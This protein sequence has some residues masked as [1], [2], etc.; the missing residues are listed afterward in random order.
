MEYKVAKK[1]RDTSF[2]D[3]V[4]Q[5]PGGAFASAGKAI[6]LKMKAKATGFQEKFDPM[7]MAKVITGGSRWAPAL[8]GR[9]TGRKQDSIEHFAG[10]K[11]QQARGVTQIP[12]MAPQQEGEPAEDMSSVL[13]QMFTFMKKTREE[14]VKARA[15]RESFAEE[16]QNE[17]QRKHD[18]FIEVLRKYTNT[19]TATPVKKEGGGFMDFVKQLIDSVKASFGTM[20]EGVYKA[21]EWI[22]K[23]GPKLKD[24]VGFFAL[25]PIGIGLLAG[26]TLLSLL[27]LDKNAEETTKGILGAG[28]EGAVGTEIMKQQEENV[29][30]EEIQKKQRARKALLKDAP[31][32]TRVYQ[33]NAD[34]YLEKLGV[35]KEDRANL[36][37]YTV[38]FK[39]PDKLKDVDPELAAE[40][41]NTKMPEA[42]ETKVGKQAEEASKP[43]IPTTT[44]VAPQPMKME[45]TPVTE[46]PKSSFLS[47]LI[48]E[49]NDLNTSAI[50]GITPAPGPIVS[51]TSSAGSI[52]DKQISSSATQRDTTHILD[53]VQQAS[54]VHGY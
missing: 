24:I 22:T 11:R 16:R 50:A 36:T 23:L 38:P 51:G 1:I 54:R 35:S 21:F 29:S 20:L 53:R 12:M 32:M 6:S 43:A 15:L 39:V 37:N 46:A 19:E 48:G 3:L 25:N 42:K 44:P 40:L 30:P 18:E 45:A 27:A 10:N 7:N 9:I 41:T 5:A 52:P 47:R 14:D 17:A 28:N 4:R 49:N 8:L 13:S 33:V 2:A 31:F 34:E 26:A